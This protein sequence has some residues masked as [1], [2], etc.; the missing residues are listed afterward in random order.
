VQAVRHERDRTKQK[1]ANN[2]GNHHGGTDGDNSPRLSL[3]SLMRLPE[4]HVGMAK[5]FYGVRVHE[6]FSSNISGA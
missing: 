5:I 2:L 1:A 4:K 3:V 6:L